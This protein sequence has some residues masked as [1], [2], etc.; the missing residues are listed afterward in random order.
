M[1]HDFSVGQEEATIRGTFKRQGSIEGASLRLPPSATGLRSV[2]MLSAMD[3]QIQQLT[4]NRGETARKI[5]AAVDAQRITKAEVVQSLWSGYGRILRLHLHGGVAPSVIVKWVRPGNESNQPRGWNTTQSH[6]RKM[7]SYEVEAAWYRRWAP[8][9]GKDARVATS[10]LIEPQSDEILF[11][12]E[13]LDLAGYPRRISHPDLDTA[14]VCLSWLA[15][16]H[17]RQI[18]DTPTGLWPEGTYWHLETRPDEWAALPSD[19][20]LRIHG[21]SIDRHLRQ[22]PF[23]TIVHGDA[24]IANFCFSQDGR[25]V[26]AVDFQYV[27]G[28]CGMK[29]VAYFLGSCFDEDD[30]EKYADELLDH[31]FERLRA[32]MGAAGSNALE[33]SWRAMYPV[34]WADFNRFLLG[35]YPGHQKLHRYSHEMTRQAIDTIEQASQ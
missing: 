25:Q 17:A 8:G 22:C 20:P 35:W 23:Q 10:Y 2:A 9:L 11:V 3:R 21:Q 18:G 1:S 26:A 15:D 6:Q 12:F 13:D 19:A 27:G 28:G 34:A 24:K 16:F 5:L 7:R 33:E 32:E 14:R 4:E 29:D 30:C 31:Y